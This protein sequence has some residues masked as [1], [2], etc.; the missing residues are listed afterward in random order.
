MEKKLLKFG[1]SV[2]LVID[3][4]LRVALGIKPTTLVRV[5]TDGKRLIIEPSGER[6]VE[7]KRTEAISEHMQARSIAHALTFLDGISN[8]N[9]ARLTCGWPP[10]PG[11]YCMQQYKIWLEYQPW[12]SLTDAEKRVVARFEEVYFARRRKESWE[13]AITEALRVVPFDP[14]DPDERAVGS[15]R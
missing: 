11:R 7:S 10:R 12:E 5:M 15:R 6:T 13:Q 4:P 9:F 14:D 8:E 2:A 3:K 1:N